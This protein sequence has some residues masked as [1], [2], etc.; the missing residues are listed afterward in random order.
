MADPIIIEIPRA[1]AT[2]GELRRRYRHP[3]A[4][5][6]Y[7]NQWQ[8]EL[9]FC[10]HQPQK[11]KLTKHADQ[12]GKV[13]LLITIFPKHLWDPDNLTGAMKPL[14]DAAKHIGY[15]HDDDP[16]H[17]DLEVRQMKRQGARPLTILEFELVGVK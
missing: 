8:E 3:H 17:L 6:D 15:L 13:R 5:K 9:M 7:R 12:Q 11:G 14:I 2:A 1:P 10:L 16:A 4:Y